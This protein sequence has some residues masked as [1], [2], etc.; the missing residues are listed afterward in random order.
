MDDV[1]AN[2]RIESR[3]VPVG[4]GLWLWWVLAGMAGWGAGGPLGVALGNPG[5]IIENGYMSISLGGI[6][7]GVLQW[8]ALRR[9]LAPAGWWAAASI[10]GAVVFGVVVFGGMGVNTDVAWIVGAILFAPVAGLVQW[11]LVLRRHVARGAGWWVPAG[12]VGFF[13]GVTVAGLVG[14]AFGLAD[15]EGG[16]DAVVVW[17][18]IGAV[19]GAITGL[20]LV[21]LLRRPAP[22]AAVGETAP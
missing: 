11:R 20:V 17:T 14:A 13:A 7:T 10:V 21:K 9:R 16:S 2:Q 12:L 22:G 8:L 4:R 1:T 5:Y 18:V 19:Y 15:K 3:P 6:I